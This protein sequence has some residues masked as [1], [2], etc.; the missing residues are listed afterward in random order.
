MKEK[1]GNITL[2]YTYYPGEDLYSDGPV[3]KELLE[4][5]KSCR[6]EEL[7][8]VI[9]EKNSWPVLY[10]FSH[11][12]E[13]ILEWI[14]M[15]GREKVLEIGSGCGAVTGV[16]ARKAGEVT[17]IDLSRM[18][19]TINA[20]RNREQENVKLLVGNFRDIERNLTDTYDLITLIGVFEYACGYMGTEEPYEDMLR[21]I[22]HHLAPGGRILLAIENRLGLKYWAGCAEDHTGGYFDGIQGYPSP[23]GVRTFSRGELLKIFEKAGDFSLAFYYPY[24]DY[25]FP[26]V[27]YSDGYLPKKGDFKGNVLNF[28]RPRMALFDE[29]K[30]FDSLA[31]TGMFP[32]FSNSFFVIAE[33]KKD[34]EG[35]SPGAEI[36]FTKYSNERAGKFAIRTDILQEGGRRFVRKTALSPKGRE[37][38][39]DLLRWQELLN[40]EYGEDFRCNVCRRDDGP[41][42]ESRRNDEETSAQT[43]CEEERTETR[44][45]AGTA[46]V[47]L[48]YVEGATLEETLDELLLRGE[49]EDAARRLLAYL[50]QVK[51]IHDRR[52]FSMTEKFRQVFAEEQIP[53]T[54]TC[55]EVTNI[56]LVCSN[57]IPGN[58]S[59]VLDYEWTFDFPI[60]CKFV[61]YRI[62]H[63]YLEAGSRPGRLDGE[64]LYREME[65]SLEERECF[66]RMERRFQEYLTQG[67]CAVREMYADISPGVLEL[68]K[69]MNQSLQ[70]FFNRGKGY[71]E[72]DSVSYPFREGA[73]SVKV[74]LPP[75]CVSLRL[76]P[77]D[78][79]CAAEVER[80][81]F[82]RV[83]VD[84]KKA[85][86]QDG[87]VRG[88]WVYIAREDPGI[89]EIPV[90]EGAKTLTVIMKLH[91]C[92]RELAEQLM[93]F[94]RVRQEL[95]KDLK[96]ELKKE[97]GK[98]KDWVK[99][100][101]GGKGKEYLRAIL[102]RGVRMGRALLPGQGNGAPAYGTYPYY[103]REH[104]PSPGELARQREEKFSPAP[105]FSIV[106]PL[107]HT[108][109]KLLRA[110]LDSVIAQSYENWELC[111]ADGSEGDAAEKLIRKHYGKERRIR[112]LHLKKNMG[113]SGNTNAA[114]KMARGDYL[115]FADHDDMLTP[116]A[117]YE[118][119][120]M[121][122]AH[123]ETELLY[124]DEDLVDGEGRA[125][126]P[127][128]KPDY[129]PDLLLCMN[130]ICHLTVVKKELQQRTGLLRKEFDGSQ[131]YDFLLRCT[132]QTEQIRHIPRVLYHWRM[133]EGSTAG[134]SGNKNYAVQ[135]GLRALREHYRRMEIPARAMYTGVTVVYRTRYEISGTPLVSV[136]IPNKDHG[137]DLKRCVDSIL[138]KTSWTAYE[139]LI[140]ENNSEQE[141]TFRCYRELEEKDSRI[142]VLNYGGEFNYSAVNNFGAEWA[143]GEYLLL[144]N[145]D[146]EVIAGDWMER[147][148]GY[149]QREG[150]AVA[151]AKLLYPD[152]RVQHAGVVVGMGGFAGHVLTGSGREDAGYLRRLI[153]AQ[154][155]SAV[156]GACM[157]IKRT[158]YEELGGMDEDF[159]VALNDVDLCLRA[160]ELGQKVVFVPEAL[161]YHYESKTRG[162]EDTILKAERFQNE[163]R[164][165]QKRHAGIL[166]S[167]DP[168][169]NPNL[170]LTRTDCSCRED[171]RGGRE[172]S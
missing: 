80:L 124:S 52:P 147:L 129:N 20:Y 144:L 75:D 30:A 23:G 73:I 91:P 136:L 102:S 110:F 19:S 44:G 118:C 50:H 128:F 117:L 157:M 86:I 122:R 84:L 169:Y 96:Q 26:M 108:P 103:E 53:G 81:S 40:E 2:D 92:D 156:T 15:T 113:I 65:I 77:G 63:Y 120:N 83:P 101:E 79:P 67:H 119:A 127:H 14:P 59:W 5:A 121:L 27:L 89:S 166:K 116:D 114:I 7:N 170:S 138:E 49:K 29:G 141:E 85:V 90:P 168:F 8:R 105:L 162:P 99:D 25:K 1:I 171:E 9:R 42:P 47:C 58:P 115:A 164:R 134:S 34:G 22:S 10:H 45:N 95:K 82:G 68:K 3:E 41:S 167:G 172:L 87:C 71:R 37:H 36:L 125:L 31:D 150:T 130:Y 66:A 158:V 100:P 57:L 104:R 98:A 46:S 94:A 69:E 18:R 88:S 72:E 4:I 142:R 109:A 32:E 70:I 13:N 74:K 143:N 106:T 54:H 165:F 163:I 107:Y 33:K 28:D 148:L 21:R 16:L 111:L 76:D 135:A 126:V 38:V 161:L 160:G 132:E 151:G 93:G 78:L 24:P 154:E 149:C 155:V 139:I 39:E 112:Y 12:R 62:L 159:A 43:G 61:L 56:D 123:P 133:H 140:L 137:E 17:C 51:R 6:E 55:A 35:G 146:T 145:N 64:A 152:D 97:Y 131:D 11:I 48:E 153:T 60:P